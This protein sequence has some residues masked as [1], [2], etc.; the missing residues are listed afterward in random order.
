M[1]GRDRYFRPVMEARLSPITPA[2]QAVQRPTL[3]YALRRY[4]FLPALLV[5][6]LGALAAAVAL[7]RDPTYE[8]ETLLV[9]GKVDVETPGLSGF[10]ATTESLAS[11]YSRAVQTDAVL[12]PAGRE[13][14]ESPGEVGSKVSASPVPESPVFRV[15]AESSSEKSAIALANATSR[16]LVTYIGEINRSS[17]RENDVIQQ[18]TDALVELNRLEDR[19]DQLRATVRQT[20]TEANRDALARAEA[21]VQTT[22]LRTRTLGTAYRASQSE[23]AT[24][25]VQVLAPARDA[26]SDRRQKLQLFVLI[27]VG[28][29]LALGIALARLRANRAAAQAAGLA[30]GA[31][32]S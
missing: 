14:G 7:A 13:V 16:S 18:L 17:P 15:R 28:A 23:S 21:E 31:R 26:S 30:L 25:L 9:V 11:A 10:V 29:G 12:R 27:G 8:A 19:R 1:L 32:R 2:T 4:W 20:P 22:R 24:N 5:V 3:L 6:L